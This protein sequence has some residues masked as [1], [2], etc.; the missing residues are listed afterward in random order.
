MRTQVV[1]VNKY[2]GE[3][4]IARV[5]KISYGKRY[6]ENDQVENMIALLIK[7]KE[8]VPFEFSSLLFYIRCS[9]SCHRQLLQ[10]R[11]SSRIT[12][13]YRRTLPLEVEDQ[14]ILNFEDDDDIRNTLSLSLKNYS[15]M[16]AKT[17]DKQKSKMVLPLSSMTEMYLQMNMRSILHFLEERLSKKSEREIQFVANE[18]KDVV[19]RNY[20]YIYQSVFGADKDV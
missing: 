6:I 7:N 16:Y 14:S 2:G 20:P 18:I 17:G 15:D 11:M 10:Y 8:M 13:S 5:A 19:E 1:L 12:R 4:V 3:D 9:L